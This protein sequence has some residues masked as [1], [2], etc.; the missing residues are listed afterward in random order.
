MIMKKDCYHRSREHST[1]WS[2]VTMRLSS[3][4]TEI[5]RLKDNGVTSLTFW[6]HVTSV[7]CSSSARSLGICR[8]FPGRAFFSWGS[9][10]CLAQKTAV[11]LLMLA[12]NP[13][14]HLSAL[15]VV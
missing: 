11:S 3:T 14:R 2:I 1:L 4:V 5:R 9:M 8:V 12:K 7:I 13:Q 15:Q 6:S 10:S